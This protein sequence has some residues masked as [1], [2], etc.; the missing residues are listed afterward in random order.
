M[1]KAVIVGLGKIGLEYD[2]DLD[3]SHYAY[4]HV[5]A[6]SRHPEVELIFGVDP[7]IR[8]RQLLEQRYGVI[9]YA[10]VGEIPRNKNFDIL[11][12]SSSTETRLDILKAMLYRFQPKIVLCEKPLAFNSQSAGSIVRLCREKNVKLLVNYIRRADPAVKKIK[13]LI[14]KGK[15]ETP[16]RGVC[17]YSKGILH[18]GSHF[19]DLMSYWLGFPKSAVLIKKVSALAHGDAIADLRVEF[20]RGVV[21]FICNVHE[22][23]NIHYVDLIARNGILNYD[24]GGRQIRWKELGNMLTSGDRSR[25]TVNPGQLIRSDSDRY[26]LNVLQEIVNAARGGITELTSG[27]EA[28]HTIKIIEASL[29]RGSYE[30]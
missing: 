6:T 14:G 2:L 4:T 1:L 21:T 9:S 12:I 18:N 15:I 24:N 10:S 22:H 30:V 20:Q 23:L 17:V 29:E 26:Q 13:A 25:R 28:L 5:R 3:P 7:D 16:V 27:E 19:V 8:K 11:I